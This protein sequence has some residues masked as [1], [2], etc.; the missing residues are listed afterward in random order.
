MNTDSKECLDWVI[1][2]GGIHGTHIAI[3]LLSQTKTKPPT[4]RIVD[5][6]ACLLSNWKQQTA[7]TKM[8]S[9]RSPSVHHLAVAPFALK[10]FAGKKP[11]TRRGKFS[12]PCHRPKLNF[13]NQ[14]CESLIK[15][16]R[17]DKM[18]VSDT[19]KCLEVQPESVTIKT[20]T[21]Q[22]LKSKKIVLALG[23]SDRLNIPAWA[24]SCPKT[25]HIF[26]AS[27]DWK[28]VETVHSIAVIGGGI[29]AI[30]IALYA[31]SLGKNVHLISRHELRKHQFDSDP[32]WLGPKLMASFTKE[33]DY[34]KRR[35]IIKQSRHI[36]SVPPELFLAMKGSIHSQHICFYQSEVL[37]STPSQGRTQLSLKNS[38]QIDVDNV[39]LATGFKKIRPGGQMLDD[40]IHQHQ[41]PV[42]TCGFP[43]VNR[44]LAWH[45]RI[46]VSGALAELEVGPTAKNISG[47]RV[48]AERIVSY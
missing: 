33:T 21:G 1:I 48:I 42:A 19:A 9:L 34:K 30:Q 36:G 44:T 23:Q 8:K 28:A 10:Q 22:Q 20:Q 15:H 39:I 6:H 3:Q 29:T 11:K 41:L 35:D 24:R 40:L 16:F 27:F 37:T 46:H 38:K 14:H 2:G 17:L 31:K 4:L 13:F 26:S 12:Y 45:P 7:S 43:I 5:P 32:G 25:S 47:A 18:H